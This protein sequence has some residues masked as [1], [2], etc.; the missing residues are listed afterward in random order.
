MVGEIRDKDTAEAAMQASMTGH[1]VLS[2]LHTNDA[3]SAIARL[4]DIG[5]ESYLIG[6]TTTGVMAQRLLR[7]LCSG[8]KQAYQTP[9]QA[10]GSLFR[11]TGLLPEG[12]NKDSLV[13]LYRPVGCAR[14]H[15]TG[16]W[17]RHGI[18]EL[19]IVNDEIRRLIHEGAPPEVMQKAAQANGMKTLREGGYKLVLEGLTTVEE[20]FQHTV[21]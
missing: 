19:L 2:T 8:C 12:K 9:V 16:F 10:L 7:L 17:G 6:A 1:L 11:Q 20:V 21:D 13:T 3:A 5:I 15:G 14:C 4:R 18:Y